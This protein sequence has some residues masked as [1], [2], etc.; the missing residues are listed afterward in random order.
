LSP[1]ATSTASVPSLDQLGPA[2]PARSVVTP[3]VYVICSRTAS[4]SRAALACIDAIAAAAQRLSEIPASYA[5][6]D[7]VADRRV[8]RLLILLD[9]LREVARRA[10]DEAGRVRAS[11][12]S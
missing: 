1:S 5:P 4:S 7:G 8:G 3:E 10:L 2:A 12:G 9:A 11:P 6:A